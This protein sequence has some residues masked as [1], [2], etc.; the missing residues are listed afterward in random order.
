MHLRVLDAVALVP[1]QFEDARGDVRALRIEHRVV[2]GERNFFEDAFGAILV[3]SGPAAVFALESEHP[4]E[5][6]L[7]TFV[8]FL[9]IIGGNFAECEEDHGGVVHIRVPFVFEFEAPAA[10]SSNSKTNGPRMWTTPPWSSSH[11]AKFPPMIAINATNVS[12]AASNGCSL[13]SAKTAAG[14]LLTRIAPKASS[15]KFL[16]PITTRCSILSART[17]P[18]ASS[19]CLGTRATASSTRRCIR[20]YVSFA[21]IRKTTALGMAVGASIIFMEPGR[22]SA[23]CGL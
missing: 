10:G 3:K 22:S 17:S 12:S 2:I 14:P 8:A 9:A 5:A 6:A 7:E 11:S 19:N 20:R 16:S 4:F 18:R 23:A 21:N 15:K 13:S 1:K